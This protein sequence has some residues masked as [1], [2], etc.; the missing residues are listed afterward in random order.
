MISRSIKDQTNNFEI[1]SVHDSS[2]WGAGSDSNIVLSKSESTWEV[3]ENVDGCY[4]ESPSRDS[5]WIGHDWQ[6]QTLQSENTGKC[7]EYWN[8]ET[9]WSY[10]FQR[11]LPATDSE[12]GEYDRRRNGILK[13]GDYASSIM[14]RKDENYLRMRSPRPR[15]ISSTM[16]TVIHLG[17]TNEKNMEIRK[18]RNFENVEN[19]FIVTENLVMTNSTEILKVSK[20]DCRSSWS[21]QEVVKDKD[22]RLLGLIM[23]WENDLFKRR[24]KR[25]MVYPSGTV[26]DVLHS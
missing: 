21:S 26:Q 8:L 16:K 13:Y 1:W 7:S 9:R 2:R 10:F 18:Y 14:P 24:D 11:Q 12:I 4:P 20:N 17:L 19:S 23:S 3:N 25:K 5:D 15:S 6:C 22:T